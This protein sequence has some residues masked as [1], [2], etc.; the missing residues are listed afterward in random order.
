[1]DEKNTVV[2]VPLD[3]T[4][5]QKQI[6]AEAAGFHVVQVISEPAAACLAY[7][8]G[9]LGPTESM[10]CLV[11]CCGGASLTVSLVQINLGMFSILKSKTQPIGGDQITDKI[12]EYLAAEFQRKYK[13]DPRETK[14]A[15][16]LTHAEYVKHILSTVDTANCYIESLY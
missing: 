7:S 15:K 14:Q 8:L 2:T 5:D 6:A 3:F 12:V 11:C 9:Q 1:M 13:A 10:K 4:T 16:L